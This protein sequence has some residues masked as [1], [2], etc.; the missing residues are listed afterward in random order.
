MLTGTDPTVHRLS[1]N[2][3]EPER[4]YVGPATVFS[5]AKAA[6][7][8][9]VMVVGKEKLRHL[10]APGTVDTFVLAGRGDADVANEAIVQVQAGFDVM[11][12]HFPDTDLA[13]HANG[14]LSP[15][16]LAKVA[17]ADQALGRL[18]SALPPETTVI[19]SADHGG[20]GVAH[21][22]RIPE[23]MTI[24]WIIAGPR[25]SGG[26]E[27]ATAVQTMDTAATALYVLGLQL[28]AG[29]AGTIVRE[30]FDSPTP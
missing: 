2:E 17:E 20:R 21:G 16:Y 3:Y 1:W 15:T 10:A 6:G 22:Y 12:V 29:C 19:L 9:T 14:W 24:P 27:L 25:A 8:R 23:D 30:A 18:L 5:V 4:G 28:P 26:R 11:F 13:G 7:L